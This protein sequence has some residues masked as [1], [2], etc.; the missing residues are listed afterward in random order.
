MLA[1]A[2]IKETAAARMPRNFK[3]ERAFIEREMAR[4]ACS[5]KKK[6]R[7]KEYKDGN[8]W[9]EM[10]CVEMRSHRFVNR[11]KFDRF[12]AFKQVKIRVKYATNGRLI[13]WFN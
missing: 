3:R 4:R 10:H 11:T 8:E 12:R 9:Y 7:R 13:R 2:G 6:E 5:E 1:E